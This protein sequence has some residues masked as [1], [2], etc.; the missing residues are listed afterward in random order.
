VRGAGQ[1]LGQKIAVSLLHALQPRAAQEAP[2]FYLERLLSSPAWR[3]ITA[4]AAP[5]QRK[6]WRRNQP[7]LP[8]VARGNELAA[9]R[10]P[11]AQ[12]LESAP[13]LTAKLRLLQDIF[14]AGGYETADEI[15]L[16]L[17]EAIVRAPRDVRRRA[18]PLLTRVWVTVGATERALR[19]WQTAGNDLARTQPLRQALLLDARA[20]NTPNWH[21][22]YGFHPYLAD[23]SNRS[24][25]LD[26][27]RLA[28][29]LAAH[30]W[31]I[32]RNPE[33]ELVLHN[34]RRRGG[35]DGVSA[36]NRYLVRHRL[37]PVSL[38]ARSANWLSDVSF[39]A[40]PPEPRPG[41]LVS[42]IM[43]AR[44][45]AH[46]IGYAVESI[47]HQTYAC[48][49]LLIADDGSDDGTFELVR[50]RYASDPR[51]RLFR[52]ERNQGTYNTRNL[53]I[54][55]ARGDLITFQ[56]ADDLS[57]PSRLAQQVDVT[58]RAGRVGCISEWLRV[59]ADGSVAFFWN[60]RAARLS[61]V[62][63]MVTRE[64]LRSAG[65]YPPA[66]VGADLDLYRRVLK[67]HGDASIVRLDTPLLLGLWSDQSLTRSA[68]SESLESG[69]RAPVRR[70]YS[71]LVFRRDLLGLESLPDASLV[72]ELRAFGNYLPPSRFVAGASV[73]PDVG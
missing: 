23:A 36:F 4:L 22:E 17:E 14:T 31:A 34:A 24:G 13:S 5:R 32:L 7:A 67:R 11:A 45:A 60:G 25:G 59:R 12:L 8:A 70:R 19:L 54:E 72:D 9:R 58:R 3:R 21:S 61:I 30:P 68:T 65:S 16:S 41:P 37:P 20:L 51:V 71:E 6:V 39:A 28:D 49:E 48:I 40:G 73:T 42:V 35:S 55:R 53:L 63:L 50:E 18:L 44:N 29:H 52:S 15:A 62:S 46:T 64:A 47:L 26:L 57:L 56:D 27:A 2:D 66:K 38:R 10:E 1:W 69:Y 43:S 33:I